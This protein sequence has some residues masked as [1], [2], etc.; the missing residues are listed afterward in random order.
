M[1]KLARY[2][3]IIII[4]CIVGTFITCK[5]DKCPSGT[6]GNLTL[7][8]KTMHH[9]NYIKGCIVKIKFGTQDFPGESAA[10]DLTQQAGTNDSIVIVTG[11]K[12]G[13]YYIYATGADSTL[14]STDKTVKGGIPYST[15]SNDGV[16]ELIL[17]VTESH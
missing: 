4:L 1:I 6:G 7:K 13:D 5:K 3:P 14:T 2:T 10:F 12:C 8:L 9:S 15:T 16:V 17:P 11:L